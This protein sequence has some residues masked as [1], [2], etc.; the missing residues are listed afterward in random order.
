MKLSKPSHVS[1]PHLIYDPVRKDALVVNCDEVISL[2]G[3]FAD[4]A[5]ANVAM[6]KAL[7]EPRSAVRRQ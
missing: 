6:R 1:T 4:Y 3:P 2:P 5:A 7:E